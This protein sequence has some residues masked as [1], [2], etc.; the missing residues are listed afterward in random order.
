MN[1]VSKVWYLLSF[2]FGCWTCLN[3]L[4]NRNLARPVKWS[5]LGFISLLLLPPLN[6]Y[7]T[8]VRHA[9]LP[10]LQT[11]SCQLTWAYGPLLVL[12]IRHS[13]LQATPH[14]LWH[15]APLVLAGTLT[16][17]QPAWLNPLW[18]LALL[19]I[20]VSG[21]LMWAARLLVQHRARLKQLASHHQNSSY[22][23]LLFLAGGLMA[24]TMMDMVIYICILTTGIASTALI[25]AAASALALYVNA[26]ALFA[27]YQP[28]AL[29]PA[30]ADPVAP[31]AEVAPPCRI[32]EL[33]PQAARELDQ[34]LMALVASHQPHLD[35]DISLGKLA[36]LLGITSH[37]LSELLNIHKETSFYD[38]L[39]ELRF[40][41]ALRLLDNGQQD[42]TIAD[43]AYRS[44]FNNRN[45]FYKV[46][47]DKTGV[48]PGQYKKKT[49]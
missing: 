3:C 33:S 12:V 27:M 31:P 46:F 20:Q 47:K 4:L 37:Q 6:A 30:G 5:I 35:E 17:L 11:I 39:N 23:W 48:T 26:I 18:F 16:V 45:T 36:A 9:P 49:A 42:V 13:L 21:Y 8:L 14:A 40:Q 19:F 22:Y 28:A 7:V 15:A 34:Q 43:I 32:I 38:F 10:W 24:A 1:E 41:E 44:G 25:S 29:A 2:S